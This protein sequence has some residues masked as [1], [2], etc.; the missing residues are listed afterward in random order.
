MGGA[1]EEGVR[2]LVPQP[3]AIARIRGEVPFVG[4]SGWNIG[5]Q[6]P[7]LVSLPLEGL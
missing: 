5:R 2:H 3:Q 6:A 1:V 7:G 4:P